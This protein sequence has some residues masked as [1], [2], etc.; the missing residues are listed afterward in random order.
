MLSG[1]SDISSHL[2]VGA[3]PAGLAA[4]RAFRSQGLDVE[5]LET[6]QDVG[7]IWDQDNPGSPMYDSAHF[8]SSARRSGF[9][10]FPMP[11]HFPDYPPHRLLLDYLRDFTR[12][13]GLYDAI[14]FGIRV[15]RAIPDDGG[16]TVHASD[17]SKRRYATL[18]AA[19]GTT[20]S[21]RIPMWPGDFAG[22]LV[23]SSRYRSSKEFHGKRVLIV[24]A[25]NS[26]VDIACDAA[27]SA[28]RATISVRR[29]YHLIPK[30]LFGLPAD[31]FGARGPH[32]PTAIR[33]RVFARTLRILNGDLTRHGWPRPD[34]RLFETHPIVNDQIVHH[35]RHGDITVRPDVHG[36]DGDDVVFVDG[37]RQPVDLVVAATGYDFALPYIDEAL[38]DWRGGRPQ[39]YLQTF[40]PTLPRFAALGLA[41]FDG[42]AWPVFDDLADLIARGFAALERGESTWDRLRAVVR[43]PAPDVSGGVRHVASDRHAAYLH[44]AS[45]SAHI[46][47]IRQRLGWPPR[48][49]TTPTT[50]TLTA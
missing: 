44:R 30:H 21:P 2:I 27:R 50:P 12:A 11:E 35:L 38:F 39:L 32:L 5:V 26:G 33:Q 49:A 36:F 31:E 29:G 15:E 43:G 41:E 18:T 9:A 17:G 46:R 3:G 14:R 13:Y 37:T 20:W 23:H 28:S 24:G 6:H 40:S 25:G 16:W 22:D 10:G 4:A 42:A 48:V 7:G 47:D 34:H 8:I 19:S 45:L 1:L